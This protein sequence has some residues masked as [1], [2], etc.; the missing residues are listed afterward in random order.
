MQCHVGPYQGNKP[1]IFI[2]FLPQDAAIVYPIIE[3][4]DMEGCRVFYDDGNMD[5]DAVLK[6]LLNCKVCIAALSG[7]A[8]LDHSFREEITFALSAK[9]V[10]P[11]VLAEF[12]MRPSLRL[13]LECTNGINVYGYR[14]E[15][16]AYQAIFGQKDLAECREENAKPTA[17]E[18]G[19]WRR[20][21]RDY[22]QLSSTVEDDFG[23]SSV[24]IRD[25]FGG[26]KKSIQ[27]EKPEP[28][29]KEP[30]TTPEPEISSVTNEKNA[31]QPDTVNPDPEVKRKDDDPA[32]DDAL[33]G[34]VSDED[35]ERT[36]YEETFE[37]G[38]FSDPDGRTVIEDKPVEALLVRLMSGERF[39]IDRVENRLGR[40]PSQVNI[41]IEGNSGISKVHAQIFQTKGLF[42]IQDR[43]STY[44]TWVDGKQLEG[45]EVVRLP[46]ISIIKLTDEE[47]VFA[48]GVVKK[49]IEQDGKLCI[50]QAVKTGERKL[51]R[52]GVLPLNR[53]T[54]WSDGVLSDQRISRAKNTEVIKNG[55][56]CRV[57]ARQSANGTT[58]NN[59]KME[60]DEEI[61]LKHGDQIC[62]G[63][64]EQFEY[65]E[66]QLR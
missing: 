48:C 2:S 17:E 32:I 37:G 57:K 45:D 22:M 13:F 18:L 55:N 3:R 12:D 59:R 47:F 36:V 20:R 28:D 19:A 41:V 27:K 65:Q 40:S 4:L 61:K 31:V 11:L 53:K 56:E 51:L 34:T 63:N 35:F 33:D 5:R 39:V 8:S 66:I 58:L 23:E 54:Q 21:A 6:K 62:V 7:K 1:F 14:D 49:Q 46:E 15:E 38:D 43:H 24:Y 50:L 60:I 25:W 29:K 16:M 44:G 52:E 64:A 10:I 9:K 30:K 26:K 42:R